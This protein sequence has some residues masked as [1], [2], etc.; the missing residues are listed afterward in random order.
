VKIDIIRIK[1]LLSEIVRNSDDLK[2]MVEK[3]T[4]RPDSMELKATKYM[5]IPR[6]SGRRFRAKPATHSD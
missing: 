2:K 4:L 6:D 1:R 5:H 3:N